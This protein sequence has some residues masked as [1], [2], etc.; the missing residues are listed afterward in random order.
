MLKNVRFTSPPEERFCRGCRTQRE[1]AITYEFA[2]L[3]ACAEKRMSFRVSPRHLSVVFH[4]AQKWFE[5]S[6][7]LE[8]VTDVSGTTVTKT[9]IEDGD[10]PRSKPERR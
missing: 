4:C 10:R 1:S 5:F 9:A 3:G 2:A 6:G 7:I 8:A